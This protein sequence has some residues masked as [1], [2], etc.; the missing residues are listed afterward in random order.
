MNENN[1]D[2]QNEL[3]VEE[4][5]RKIGRN[6]ILF[7][8]IEGKL[9]FLVANSRIEVIDGKISDIHQKKSEKV[10]KQML[11]E[12]VKQYL[13][14]AGESPEE[15]PSA[16]KDENLF[17]ISMTFNMSATKEFF[18]SLTAD[19][20]M[21]VYERNQLIHNFLPKWNPQSSERLTD[22]A[23]YLN[24]QHEKALPIFEHIKARIASWEM[25]RQLHLQILSSDGF[26]KQFETMF[27]QQSPLV[28]FFEEVASKS[29][30]PDGWT[31][32]DHAVQLAKEHLSEE[33][34]HLEEYYGY[35]TFKQILTASELFE[36]FDEPLPNKN[37]RT[38]YRVKKMEQH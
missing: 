19:M 11:G 6:V 10:H 2:K 15:S 18:E 20:E 13:S 30:R 31:Y 12:L 36:V 34:L 32:L 14:D 33:V 26:E 27:L 7:Q 5:L 25:S 21:M 1:Q 22:A 28:V 17:S 16:L 3:L 37:F 9:K 23:E 4:V 29:H 38:L 24:K 8:Q 35:K